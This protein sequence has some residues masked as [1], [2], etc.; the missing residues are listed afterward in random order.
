MLKSLLAI[1]ILFTATHAFPWVGHD[2]KRACQDPDCYSTA[3]V[4]EVVTEPAILTT[5]LLQTDTQTAFVTINH[6]SVSTIRVFTTRTFWMSTTTTSTQVIPV[7]T[8]ILTDYIY[9]TE[10]IPRTITQTATV[11]ADTTTYVA[12]VSLTT[13]STQVIVV[14]TLVLST[15]IEYL[16]VTSTVDAT[17]TNYFFSDVTLTGYETVTITVTVPP[18]K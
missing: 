3:T 17:I 4:N 12:T 7:L 5:I 8:S 14:P 10:V 16:Y 9:T 11:T 6:T 1:C 15:S 18:P 13:T 2:Q